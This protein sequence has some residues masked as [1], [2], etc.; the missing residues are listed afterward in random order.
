FYH[1]YGGTQDNFTLGGPARTRSAHGITNADWFVT[2]SGDGFHC[3]ADPRD[4]DIVY[5][6]A[7]YGV[8]VRY[9]RRTGARMGI[10][11]QA[12]AD[13]PPLRWN[14]DS[15][16]VISPHSPTR[17]YFAA[18]KVF[19]SEDR[20]DTW[21]AISGDLTRQ[22]DRNKLPVMGKVWGPDAVSKSV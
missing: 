22:I 20:G 1:V 10:Q 4:P 8:L 13:A 5:A 11:P 18:N 17:L 21:K 19:R 9:N 15:P 7:Q 3:K 6:E 16:L 14:W 12:R 2:Q